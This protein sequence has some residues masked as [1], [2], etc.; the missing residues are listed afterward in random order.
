MKRLVLLLV[1]GVMCLTVPAHANHNTEDHINQKITEAIAGD[2]PLVWE[3]EYTQRSKDKTQVQQTSITALNTYDGHLSELTFAQ[4]NNWSDVGSDTTCSD[5][6]Y[7]T[8]VIDWIDL[9]VN[10]P[11]AD[12][13]G[14]VNGSAIDRGY[15][16][17]NSYWQSTNQ[18]NLD[19][20][21]TPAASEYD[22]CA[23]MTHEFGHILGFYDH[24][25]ESSSMCPGAPPWNMDLSDRQTMCGVIPT[26]KTYARTLESHDRGEFDDAYTSWS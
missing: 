18:W 7:H 19:C 9:G 11:L 12:G 5:A 15:V 17:I 22:L 23:V 21:K 20:D 8:I 26:G 14:C 1:V 10:G 25:S 6:S 3:L 24:W 13:Y 16:R 2:P 4:T